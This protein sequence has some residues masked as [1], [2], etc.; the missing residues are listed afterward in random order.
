[1]LANN[2]SP[3]SA[4]GYGTFDADYCLIEDTTNVTLVG[5]NNITGQDPKLEALA[6][7]GG[8]TQTHRLKPGSPA[9][10]TGS[11]PL[12]LSTDQRFTGFNRAVGAAPDIGAFEVQTPGPVV[13]PDPKNPGKDLLFI[14]GTAGN[15]VIKVINANQVDFNGA[16]I[17]LLDEFSRILAFG[18]EGNDKILVAGNLAIPALLD[19]GTGNDTLK[20]GA[21]ND[22]L[23]GQA[24]NDA[25]E[26]RLGRDLLIGGKGT[27]NQKGGAG[28]D[29]LVGGKTRYDADHDALCAILAEWASSRSY[30]KRVARLQA[31]K[32]S[33]PLGDAQISDNE[34]DTLSGQ[35]DLDLFFASAGDTL[36]N[37]SGET[38]VAVS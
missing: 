9:I 37:V 20:G 33:P 36:D 35:P 15:D 16:L 14:E 24:G 19:G 4:D 18:R 10:D 25:L 32:G 23:L 12:G 27:D 5:A 3:I 26:G 28:E 21:A 11:N 13:V 2:T 8:P 22:I 17:G 29:V 34:N 6:D 1:M 38:V 31:G 7:N 30:A